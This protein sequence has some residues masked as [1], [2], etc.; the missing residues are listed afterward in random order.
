MANSD[1]VK[2]ICIDRNSLK[3]NLGPYEAILMRNIELYQEIFPPE[4]EKKEEEEKKKEEEE[5][6]EE[7]KK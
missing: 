2:L 4:E 6:K 1:L 5:K 3:N 7:E